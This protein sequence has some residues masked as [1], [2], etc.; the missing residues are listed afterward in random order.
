MNLSGR[1]VESELVTRIGLQRLGEGA[2][3]VLVLGI[4]IIRVGHESTNTSARVWID[5][6]KRRLGQVPAIFTLFV[7]KVGFAMS[8]P[9]LLQPGSKPS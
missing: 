9:P 3:D 2:R 8:L 7:V 1:N 6:R 4:E 5:H